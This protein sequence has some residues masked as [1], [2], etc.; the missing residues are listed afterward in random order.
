M[1]KL[2]VSVP[3]K[4][5]RQE[6]ILHSIKRMHE[7]AEI[8]INE[9]LEIIPSYIEDKPPVDVKE[10]V[11]YLGESIKKLSQADYMAKTDLSWE[12]PGCH[13]ESEVADLYGIPTIRI[14]HKYVCPDLAK[15]RTVETELVFD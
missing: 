12:Y 4:G 7:I 1:K 11:W 14:N 3:M 2:F 5:R 6:D 10:A 9:R 8:M 15:E 13:T